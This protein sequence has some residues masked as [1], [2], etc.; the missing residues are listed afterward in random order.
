MLSLADAA[1]SADG[2]GPLSEQVRLHVSY[3]GDPAAWNLLLR[4]GQDLAGYAH[5]GPADPA[6]GRS[7]E[8][9][10]HPAHR[11]RGLGLTLALATLAQE[12]GLPVRLWA[13][14]DLP[15]AARLATVA[16]FRRTRI[17]W[18]MRRSLRDALAEPQLPPGVSLRAFI[19]GQDEDGWLAVNARAFASHPEQGKW[20]RADLA[21]REAAPWFDPD[22]FLLAERNGHLAGFHWTKIHKPGS[23]QA[24]NGTGSTDEPLGEV[25]V[26]GVDPAEQGTGL[27]RALTLAGLRY[28]QGREIPAVMLY[29][30]GE[31]AAA[32][33]LYGSLGFAHSA[34][35]VMYT[36]DASAP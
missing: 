30:D 12:S 5:L 36:H 34:T 17:L 11:R 18:Q 4:R 33:R 20:T 8:L 9:V 19:P 2:V 14:G 24:G 25:Y 29:V 10:I 16:S 22:G 1:A 13:H 15:A 26:I 31:N 6:E 3:G 28:L 27:G 7:G 35:D 32:I 23:G 21:H